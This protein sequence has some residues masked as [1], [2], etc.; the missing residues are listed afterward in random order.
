[1]L[2]HGFAG[3]GQLA[4]AALLGRHVD[5]HAAGL[6]ALHH[7]CSDQLGCRFA[8]NQRGGDDDVDLLGLLGVHGALGLLE[9]LAHDL[10]VA[11]AAGAFFLVIDLDEFTAQRHHLV[12]HFG[13]R[14]IGAHDGAQ[15]GRGT[16]GGQASHTG[17]GNK[18]FSRRHLA[19][20]R[21]LAVEETSEGV[22]RFNHGAIASHTG[23]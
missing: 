13:A 15:T 19:R 17:T 11:A 7:L 1:M 3:L 22:G 2:H 4:V 14:V 18:H 21:D 12:G 5:N 10:G 23:L 9:A 6:H 20:G 16:D 8:G